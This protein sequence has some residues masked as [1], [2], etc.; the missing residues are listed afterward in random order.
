MSYPPGFGVS[1]PSTWDLI[2]AAERGDAATV[3]SALRNP[4]TDPNYADQDGITALITAAFRGHA[5]VVALLLAHD[6]IDVN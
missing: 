5:P 6:A 4:R 1:Y 3:A 2:P